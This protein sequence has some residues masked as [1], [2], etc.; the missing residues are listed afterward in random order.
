MTSISRGCDALKPVLAPHRARHPSTRIARHPW[1]RR[2]ITEVDFRQIRSDDLREAEV[3][4]KLD[5]GSYRR[6]LTMMKVME[7]SAARRPQPWMEYILDPSPTG[8]SPSP[9]RPSATPIAAA[10][11]VQSAL[12]QV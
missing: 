10:A 2:K 6:L 11:R 9:G 7:V 8:R 3:A 5:E 12:A 1:P 4:A